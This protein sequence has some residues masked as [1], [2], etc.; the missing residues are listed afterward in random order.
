[1]MMMNLQQTT[2][3]Y[4]FMTHKPYGNCFINYFKLNFLKLYSMDNGGCIQQKNE[5]CYIDVK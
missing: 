4:E 3:Q 2:T 1:M 5:F